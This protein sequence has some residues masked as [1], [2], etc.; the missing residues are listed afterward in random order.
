[1]AASDH[2]IKYENVIFIKIRAKLIKL[3]SDKVLDASDGMF[4]V[5]RTWVLFQCDYGG[6]GMFNKIL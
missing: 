5:K 4:S 6:I 2:E 3:T 1:M